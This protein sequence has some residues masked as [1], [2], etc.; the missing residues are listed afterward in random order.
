M[1][2]Q[3]YPG[4]VVSTVTQITSA[5]LAGAI[6]AFNTS[7]AAGNVPIAPLQKDSGTNYTIVVAKPTVG[8]P[9]YTGGSLLETNAAGLQSAITNAVGSRR[10][11]MGQMTLN[12]VTDIYLCIVLFTI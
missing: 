12:P 10:F 3:G 1:N 4:V 6:A 8:G 9:K 2:T 7:I 11:V 5:S